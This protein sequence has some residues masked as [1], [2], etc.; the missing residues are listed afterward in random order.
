M[1][2]QPARLLQSVCNYGLLRGFIPVSWKVT[3]TMI[4]WN[5]VLVCWILQDWDCEL[6]Y[7]GNAV[8]SLS[9]AMRVSKCYAQRNDAN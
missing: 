4:P 8:N 1:L 6:W 5:V 7:K 9:E 2:L 3:V